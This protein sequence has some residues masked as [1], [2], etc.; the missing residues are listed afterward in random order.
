MAGEQL[1]H[2][3]PPLGTPGIE[4]VLNATSGPKASS[5]TRQDL[6]TANQHLLSESV[7]LSIALSLNGDLSTAVLVPATGVLSVLTNPRAMR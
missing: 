4:G 1:P 5:A 7:G 2:T 3:R 6:A